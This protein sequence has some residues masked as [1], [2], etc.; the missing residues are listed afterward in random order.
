[1][2][3]QETMQKFIELRSQGWTY[4]RLMAELNLSKPTLVN[5]SRKFQFQIQNLR[6]IELEALANK[7]LTSV[8]DRVNGLGLQLQKVEDELAGPGSQRPLHDPAL[9]PGSPIAPPAPGSHRLGPLHH[10]RRRNPRRRIPRAGPR[11]AGL[12]CGK[13]KVK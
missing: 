4:A 13:D 7:W 3:D 5:W 6:A 12:N 9:R 10:P 11:L 2:K 8:T 1:M